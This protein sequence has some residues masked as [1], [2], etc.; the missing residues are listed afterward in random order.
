MLERRLDRKEGHS[1]SQSVRQ[2]E[3]E[4]QA[5]GGLMDLLIHGDIC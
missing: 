5:G 1:G 3:E 2:P 4:R